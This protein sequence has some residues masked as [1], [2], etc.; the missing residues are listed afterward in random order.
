MNIVEFFNNHYFIA[1]CALW[2][3]WPIL[4]LAKLLLFSLPV[5]ILRTLNVVFRG[6]PPE[7]LDA[8]GDFKPAEDKPND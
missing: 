3:G 5:R 7:H 6:W 1:W 8:D 4:H 2:L